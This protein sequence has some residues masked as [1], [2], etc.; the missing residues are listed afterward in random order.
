[1]SGAA[2][3]LAFETMPVGEPEYLLA[4]NASAPYGKER[5]PAK[6]NQGDCFACDCTK[7]I[8]AKLLF[9]GED[10]TTTDTLAA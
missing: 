3:L 9:S 10:F 1:M 7:T 4:L 2:R 6:L 8:Q 5:H